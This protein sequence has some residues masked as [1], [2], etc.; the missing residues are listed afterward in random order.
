MQVVE[1][2]TLTAL[3]KEFTPHFHEETLVSCVRTGSGTATV[4]DATYRIG[5][6]SLVIVPA[7]VVHSC[8]PDDL[9]EWSYA[10]VFVE[11][12]ESSA[13]ILSGVHVVWSESPPDRLLSGNVSSIVSWVVDQVEAGTRILSSDRGMVGPVAEPNGRDDPRTRAARWLK[14]HTDNSVSLAELA[15][16]G[17]M[18]PY[19]LARQFRSAYGLPPHAYHLN[20]RV[21]VAKVL[22]RQGESPADTAFLTGFCD[23]SHFHR[24]FVRH[25]GLTPG[26][27]RHMVS[28]EALAE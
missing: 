12:D 2:K 8:N 10:A 7:G 5:P 4:A 11:P 16:A 27:Y 17:G 24:V 13:G 6:G 21:N 9:S 15:D 23:Q 22:L 20:V 28:K 18:S 26:R 19:E 3:S 25:V 1:R 14:D